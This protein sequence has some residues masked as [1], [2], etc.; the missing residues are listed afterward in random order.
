MRPYSERLPKPMLRIGPSSL[1]ERHLFQLEMLGYDSAMVTCSYH[2]ETLRLIAGRWQFK[3]LRVQFSHEGKSP[4]ETA[5]GVLKAWPRH[6]DQPVTVI[7]GDIWTDF[8]LSSLSTPPDNGI[9]LVL[10]KNPAHNPKGDF[11]LSQNGIVTPPARTANTLTF[12]GI[13][14]IHPGARTRLAGTQ[15]LADVIRSLI[16]SQR[17][18]AQHHEGRWYDVGSPDSLE[19]R[20]NA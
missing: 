5:A 14:R 20:R 4:I 6:N 19:A 8:P 18:S 7:N 16:P 17:A 1:L 11:C 12:A 9:H 13:S 2:S 3:R 10:V 15:G